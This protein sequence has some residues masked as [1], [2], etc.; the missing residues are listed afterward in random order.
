MFSSIKI[1]SSRQ[2]RLRLGA[3]LSGFTS[4]E[5]IKP[6]SKLLLQSLSFYRYSGYSLEHIKGRIKLLGSAGLLLLVLSVALESPYPLLLLPLI[7]ALEYVSCQQLI[8]R[9]AQLFEQDYT[10]LLMAQSSSVRTGQDPL[11][12][13]IKADRLFKAESLVR[14]ELQRLQRNLE[15]GLTEEQV[16]NRFAADIRHPD[17]G[18][19]RSALLLARQQGSSL[20]VPLQRLARVTRQ[21][22]SFRRKTRAALAMQRL[23]AVGITLCAVLITGFQIISNPSGFELAWSNST[24]QKILGLGISLLLAGMFWMLNLSRV[25]V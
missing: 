1:L 10:A 20:A 18:L 21:R 5:Q 23:S 12:A 14:L 9:R 25:R 4:I 19:F 24:G 8:N 13:L 2:E 16:I 17:I 15:S 11:A 22:Q 6:P 3:L 7:P